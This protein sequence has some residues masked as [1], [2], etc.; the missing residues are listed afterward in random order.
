MLIFKVKTFTELV[1]NLDSFIKYILD[2]ERNYGAKLGI[3]DVY[4]YRVKGKYVKAVASI[5]FTKYSI[6][7]SG[8][9]QTITMYYMSNGEVL[10]LMEYL[11]SKI[12]VCSSVRKELIIDLYLPELRVKYGEVTDEVV[13]NNLDTIHNSLKLKL[14]LW[15]LN[16]ELLLIVFKGSVSSLR[17]LLKI[18]ISLPV[19]SRTDLTKRE[20]TLEAIVRIRNLLTRIGLV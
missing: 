19:L 9:P 20:Q 5:F 4:A 3:H 10:I 1:S 11:G 7:T 16:D 15:I 14:N 2:L 8:K 17:E 18:V 13:M 12:K 6:L